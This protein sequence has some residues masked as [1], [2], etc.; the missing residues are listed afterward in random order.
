[1]LNHT[2]ITLVPK[3]KNPEC[4]SDYRHISLCNG[5]YKIVAKILSNRIKQYLDRFISWSQ[6]AFV[7]GRQ[8]LD[9][10][11]VAKELLHTMNNSYA[12]NDHFALKVDMSKAYN[13][14]NLSLLGDM[15]HL[16]GIQGMAHSLIMNYVITPSFS[17][18]INGSLQGFFKSKRGIKQGCPLFPSL[19]IICSQGL[20]IL[21]HQYESQGLVNV[22]NLKKIL[23]EYAETSGQ[24]INYTKS[25]I[26]FSRGLS[27][28]R[29]Q[30]TIQDLESG[31][32]QHILNLA[33]RNVLCKSSLSSIHIHAM[34]IC[35]LPAG[36]TNHIDKIQRCF[37][38]GHS[39]EERKMHFINW[40]KMG[41]QKD[42][43]GL[44][45]RSAEMMNKSLICKLV[46]RFLEEDDVMWVQLLSVKY[47]GDSSYWTIAPNNKASAI[48][49]SMLEVR[50]IL[51]NRIFWQVAND[52]KIRIFE[53]PWLLGYID[54]LLSRNINPTSNA[55]MFSDITDPVNNSWR[56]DLL[57]DLFSPDIIQKITEIVPSSEEADI[58]TWSCT[59]AGNFSAKS[60]YHLLA[61]DIPV[62][63]ALSQFP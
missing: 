49:N 16:M 11:I 13:R 61:N 47:L 54:H 57:H 1:M 31:W 24:Q 38:L 17:V 28:I 14:V 51:E 60:C 63:S 34:G 37:W 55:Y 27:E 62:S 12:A 46:W 7:P 43:G 52:V 19:F 29:R 59:T 9:N 2:H 15:L 20:S 4:A 6:N 53:D 18:N 40:Q 58:L 30:S 25:A 8:I 10:I 39:P 48:W 32:R 23:E 21:M 26:H 42:S 5:L 44:G 45:I 36:V 35:L 41:L 33:G 22:L 50:P 3:I 56:T